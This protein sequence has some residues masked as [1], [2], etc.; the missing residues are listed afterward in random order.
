[1]AASWAFLKAQ[2]H[3]STIA[4]QGCASHQK[5]SLNVRF[6]SG[7]DI[8]RLLSNVRFTPQSGQIADRSLSLLCAKSG[9]LHRSS[10]K[11]SILLVLVGLKLLLL[12]HG[13]HFARA[14]R[15]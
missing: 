12:L 8:A 15:G 7:A 6:G 2:D 11:R 10:P 13:W 5:R 14:G 9:L 4:G 1:R 3:G